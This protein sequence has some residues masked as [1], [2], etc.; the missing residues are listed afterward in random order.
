M[1]ESLST[2]TESKL[3]IVVAGF[4]FVL[5]VLAVLLSWST[6]KH[7]TDASQQLNTLNAR[8]ETSGDAAK[9]AQL[10]GR[11][12]AMES[13]LRL[14]AQE[15]Q[16]Y[17]TDV[18]ARF[19]DA[20]LKLKGVADVVRQLVNRQ[21]G[22]TVSGNVGGGTTGGTVGA[23]TVVSGEYVVASGDTLSGIARK[24][25]VTLSALQA[26]NPGVDSTR[27]QIGQKLKVPG[28]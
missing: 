16:T 2:P 3:P 20:F 5:A 23:G 21:G 13:E 1:D 17:K 10:E 26:A 7:A 19:T 25:G 11:L 4:A 27:L 28:R 24:V 18:D 22:G 6:R 15:Q 9:I 8:L 12:V 14:L